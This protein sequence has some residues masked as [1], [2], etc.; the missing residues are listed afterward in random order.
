MCME[1]LEALKWATHHRRTQGSL[2][3]GGGR[4]LGLPLAE[5]IFPAWWLPGLLSEWGSSWGALPVHSKAADVPDV[6]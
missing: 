1:V 6:G 4:D 2:H 3:R 5:P